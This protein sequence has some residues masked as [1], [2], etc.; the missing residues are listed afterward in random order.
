[1]I[2]IGI[3]KDKDGNPIYSIGKGIGEP[4][5][6]DMNFIAQEQVVRRLDEYLADEPGSVQVQI[7]AHQELPAGL[8]MRMRV[9][10]IRRQP[11]VAKI[12][13]GVR[14]KGGF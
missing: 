9:E 8:V 7:K 3:D 1:M 12:W 11:K 4:N 10:V 13:A 6:E 14:E 2:W 5:K